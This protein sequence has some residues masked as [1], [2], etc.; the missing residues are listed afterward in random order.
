MLEIMEDKKYPIYRFSA[1]W[2]QDGAQDPSYP[3]WYEGLPEGRI[4]NSTSWS[5]MYKEEKTQEELDQ[6]IKEW[7]EK[8]QNSPGWRDSSPLSEKHPEL[9]FLKVEYKEHESWVLDWF[10]HHTFDVGQTDEEALQSF[11]NYVDRVQKMNQELDRKFGEN[12]MIEKYKHG[13]KTLMGAEDRWRWHGADENGNPNNDQGKEDS[14][15]PCR[16]KYCKE[17]GLLRIGH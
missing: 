12:D 4:W 3:A 14:P 6:L 9:Q 17:L 13:Y 2:S 10:Q 1:R 5:E 16:C 8:Y 7:W 15:P 11:A